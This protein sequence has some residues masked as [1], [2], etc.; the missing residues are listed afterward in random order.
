MAHRLGL[1]NR[2]HAIVIEPPIAVQV[3]RNDA[4]CIDFARCL[5][6]LSYLSEC[7]KFSNV[8][9]GFLLARIRCCYIEYI[10]ALRA[11]LVRLY[12]SSRET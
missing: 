7:H 11:K 3:Q 6:A 2:L 12:F 9:D 10:F 5:L 1:Q 4:H 8:V